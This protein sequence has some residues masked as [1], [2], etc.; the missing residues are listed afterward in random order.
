MRGKGRFFLDSEI[1]RIVWLLTSTDMSIGDIAK[2]MCCSASAINAVNRRMNVRHYA[3]HRRSWRF[4][5]SN[6]ETVWRV[7][8]P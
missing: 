5:G 1:S 7:V 8:S 4:I 6:G 3:G 2:R